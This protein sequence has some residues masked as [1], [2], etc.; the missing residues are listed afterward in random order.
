M[1]E[2]KIFGY[3]NKISVKQGDEITFHVNCDGASTAEAQLVQ[4]ALRGKK[5]LGA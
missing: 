4:L 3:G 1:A 2:Q 5:V